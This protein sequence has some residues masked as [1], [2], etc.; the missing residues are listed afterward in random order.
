[1]ARRRPGETSMNASPRLPALPIWDFRGDG[2]IIS[3]GARGIGA[4]MVR[5]FSRHGADVLFGDIDTIGARQLCEELAGEGRRV[6][7]LEVDFAMADAWER[8]REEAVRLSLRPSLV[9]SNV[10]IGLNLSTEETSVEM[11]DRLAHANLRSAWLAARDFGPQLR[12]TPGSSLL[13]VGSVMASFGHPGHTLYATFKS[14]LSGLLRSLCT[15]LSPQGVRVNL[16]VPGY[17]LNDPPPLYRQTVPA[18]LWVEFHRRFGA[19][20]AEKNPPV[21]PLAF[22]G[23][24]RDIAQAASF[25][26]SPAARYITGIELRVDGGLLCQSPIKT[27]SGNEAWIWTQE[28]TAWLRERGISP[29][30]EEIPG[31]Q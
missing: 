18:E 29:S 7:F 30:A 15:E 26:H 3:G 8:L 28:M 22:W 16:L 17:I 23:E 9:V 20:V 6:H 27:G 13:L 25:L 24:P 4:E 19:E 11:F 10:G 2:L 14:A 5:H 12:Q 1:M 31:T 21:Q